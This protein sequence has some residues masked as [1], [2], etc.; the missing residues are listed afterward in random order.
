MADIGK[1]LGTAVK[2]LRNSGLVAI[3]T[4]TVYGL[5]GNALDHK[6]IL[7]IFEVKNR[8]SFDPL[9]VHL[10]HMDQ[11]SEYTLDLPEKA[12]ILA[13]KLWPGPL[14]IV[15]KKDPAIPDVA[16]SGLDS[17]AIRIPAHPLTLELLSKLDFPLVA[18]SANPF[19]YISP[20]NPEH[21]NDQLGNKIDYILDGGSSRIGIESTIITFNEDKPE[22]LRLGGTSLEKIESLIG[23]TIVRASQLNPIAPGMMES[24]YSPDKRVVLGNVV[25]L[26]NIYP[27]E[28]SVFLRFKKPVPGVN[29]DQQ[30]ILSETG[31]LEEAAQNLFSTLRILDK[32]DIKYIIAEQVPDTGLGKA[33]N[34]RLRRASA[35][36]NEI[37]NKD[38]NY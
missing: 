13:E 27:V 31:N 30:F 15:L 26:M 9:I 2:V 5:A 16:T 28:E 4:E 37:N 24:H 32:L 34:D 12:K 6:A 22:I 10:H 17:V 11:L 23:S 14:T 20:T 1:N 25:E 29:K 8:P 18:P 3:P 7:H 35:K 21:V 38:E 36:K 19:G 33:I